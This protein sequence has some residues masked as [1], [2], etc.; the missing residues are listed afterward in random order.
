MLAYT[1]FSLMYQ[2]HLYNWLEMVFCVSQAWRAVHPPPRGSCWGRPMV[3]EGFLKS[4]HANGLAERVVDRVCNILKSPDI[5]LA[6]ARVIVTGEDALR[7]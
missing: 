2:E 3:H 6:D 5:D 1:L 4:W 7:C